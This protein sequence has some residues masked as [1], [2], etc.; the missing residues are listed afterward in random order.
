[1]ELLTSTDEGVCDD[2][3]LLLD[4]HNRERQTIEAIIL[5][6]A[7]TMAAAQDNAPFL[8]AAKD[9]WHP[10]VVGIVAGRLKDRF[11][12]PSFVAGFEGGLGR[13][14]A[15]SVPGIDIGAIVRG[16][17][18]KGV[19]EFGGGHAMAAGF[20][21]RS[22]QLEGFS[23]YLALRFAELGGA[24]ADAFDLEL[25]ALLSPSGATAQ[26]VSEMERLGPFGAENA[27][28]VVAVPDARVMFADIVSKDHV[29]F[30][31]VGGDGARLDGIAFRKADTALGKGLLGARGQPIH[32]AGRLR[33][34]EWNGRIGVQLQLE[35][36]APAGV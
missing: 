25:D 35:D 33:A 31:L 7:I 36:A 29:R 8:L 22:E 19:I 30:R 28:P 34:D 23:R 26:F 17:K 9:G 4:T 1:M 20:G 5:E 16:A 13:G 27:E 15:R 18:D 2:V 3:A 11:A 6:D 14:S 32:A 10:G 24:V 12:K 21:L